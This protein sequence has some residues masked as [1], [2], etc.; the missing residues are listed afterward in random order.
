MTHRIPRLPAYAAAVLDALE[1]A[2]FE[3]WVV[4]GWVRDA[5]LGSASHDVDVCTAAPWQESERVLRAA[6]FPV[7]RT[8][9]AHGTVTVV[10]GG[11]PIEVTTYRVDGTYSD[12]RHP[13]SVR[14]VSDVREDLAR[15]DFTINAMAYHPER[16]L[17]DAFGG[18]GDLAAGLVRAVGDP[19]ARFDEDALRVLRAVRF[20]ARY[21]FGVAESTHEALAAFAPRLARIAQERIGQELAGILATGRTA[22]ALARER[23]VMVCAI[24][25]LAPLVGFAQNSPYHAFDAYEH[26]VRV[27]SGVECVTAGCA[28][29]ALRWAALLHDIA[30]PETY[31]E[32][33]SGRGHFFGH[34]ELG[35]VKAAAIMRRMAIPAQILRGACALIRLHDYPVAART[36]SLRRLLLRCEGL[37]PGR[38][39]ALAFG[40]LDLKRADALGKAPSCWGYCSELDA[41]ET[42]LRSELHA[43]APRSVRDLAVG[44]SDVIRER[45]L[46]PGPDVGMVL[47]G[48]LAAVVE[49]GIPNTREALME[50][51][52]LGDRGPLSP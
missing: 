14:F 37:C 41:V 28:G 2:G 32:D 6:G 15:R 43:A 19:R 12:A 47:D 33:V 29:P 23:A 42:A 24:P 21:G 13:D 17:L 52:R 36:R 8:G 31:S 40:L 50:L 16:G 25:E 3:A 49:D 20:A 38:G 27:V 46:E 22:W 9:T 5:L 45:G 7:H 48:L 11:R 39:G 30:K 44:G 34:P 4:G 35:A 1:S 51:L 18:A 26:T 10:V